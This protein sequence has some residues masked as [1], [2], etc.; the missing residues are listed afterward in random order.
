MF[1]LGTNAPYSRVINSPK[2]GFILLIRILATILYIME[3]ILIGLNCFTILAF[4]YLIMRI[5]IVSF[6]DLD[7]TPILKKSIVVFIKPSPIMD[8]YPLNNLVTPSI[9]DNRLD[10]RPWIVYKI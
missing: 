2:K 1:L 9:P 6:Q 7:I 3:Q 4:N 8:Q 10:P 5:T